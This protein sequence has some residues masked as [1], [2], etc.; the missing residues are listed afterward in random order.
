MLGPAMKAPWRGVTLVELLVTLTLLAVLLSLALP[1]VGPWIAR[2]Q[3]QGAQDDIQQSLELAR[4]L[5][6]T[7]QKLVWVEFSQQK[8]GW[9]MRVSEQKIANGCDASRDLRCISSEQHAG[10]ALSS[11]GKALPLQ[12][13]FSPLRGMPQ[14]ADGPLQHEIKLQLRRAACQPAE[15][16]LLSTGLIHNSAV[17]CP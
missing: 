12:L 5:A 4:K 11:P 1:A 10:I 8:D 15:L 7:R 16:Q 6:T 2:Q 3:L 14:D 13:A 17:R 9:L